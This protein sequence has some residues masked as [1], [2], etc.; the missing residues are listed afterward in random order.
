MWFVRLELSQQ[1]NVLKF[2]RVIGCI[3]VAL[4]TNISE[5][6]SVSIY[7]PDDA[8]GKIF[9]CIFLVLSSGYGNSF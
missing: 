7:D 1:I 2:S 4:K 9:P 8:F 3:S 5:I 6:S